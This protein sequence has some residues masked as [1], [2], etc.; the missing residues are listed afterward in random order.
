MLGEQSFRC[1]CGV[2]PSRARRTSARQSERESER[3]K[4][5]G[6]GR[7][8]EKETRLVRGFYARIEP[9]CLLTVLL[10]LKFAFYLARALSY[11][12]KIK[13]SKVSGV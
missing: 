5:R 3:K 9:A 11:F 1:V 2:V 12:E 10:R 8:G 6:R 7:K 4:E 13:V